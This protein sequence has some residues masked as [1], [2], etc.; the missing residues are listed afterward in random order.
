MSRLMKTAILAIAGFAL[1]TLGLSANAV[2][3]CSGNVCYNQTSTLPSLGSWTGAVSQRYSSATQYSTTAPTY[4]FSGS[5][6]SVAGLGLNESL[7]PTSC[8]VNVYN[9]NGGQVLGCYNVVK[10]VP[11]TTYYRI[12]RPVIYV[13]Y[14][15]PVAV[16]YQVYGYGYHSQHQYFSGGCAATSAHYGASRYGG[17]WGKA[18]KSRYGSPCG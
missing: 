13:R 17:K 18:K 12:V 1:P 5:T 4:G 3:G 15:V 7:R 10:P 14:P 11:Q 6:T 2:A 9:P 8:P 16:P